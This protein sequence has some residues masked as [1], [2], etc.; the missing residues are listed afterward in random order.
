M[1]CKFCD[2]PKVGLGI[3]ATF[4]DLIKQVMKGLQMHLEI[5]HTNRLNLHFARMGEPTFN[6]NVLYAAIWLAGYFDERGYGYHP[7]VSTMMPRKNKSLY[8][9]IYEWLRIKND[10]LCGNAG[11]QIS[12]N[13]TDQI[14]RRKQ[15]PQA[16][17]F[18]DIEKIL[19]KPLKQHGIKG[20]KIALNFAITNAEIDGKKLLQYFNPQYFMCKITP[21]HMTNSCKNNNLITKDGYEKYYPYK[22]A[23]ES[24]KKAGYDVL[25]FIPSKEEDESKIT[26]GNAIL[27]GK[28]TEY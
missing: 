18:D 17:E 26:C 10:L 28:T 24:L 13:T 6:N 3:N 27:S 9:F 22:E 21:M 15:M 20:R 11:L 23:E 4:N 2:V 25:I 16:L 8:N 19:R 1:G 12:I 14:C 5:K 7:V